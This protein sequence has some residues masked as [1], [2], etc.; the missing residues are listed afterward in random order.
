MT[1]SSMAGRRALVTGAAS[2]IGEAI[3]EALAGAGAKVHLVGSPRRPDRVA[4]VAERITERT[5]ASITWSSV[6]VVDDASVA[7]AVEIAAGAMGGVDCVVTSAGVSAPSD[8]ADTTPLHRLTAGQLRDVLDVNLRGTWSTLH[9]A[10]RHLEQARPGPATV[11]TLGSVAGKR[12]THGAYSVS[13]CAVWMLTRVLADQWAPLGI[14]ANCLAPGSIDTPMLR[15]VA[16]DSGADD[17]DAWLEARAAR[18]PLRRVGTVEEVAAAALFLSG[19]ES[20]YVTGALLH[21]DG[22]LVNANAGG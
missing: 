1:S 21:P 8:T 20:S 6:D 10:A 12:P 4:A 14:R 7:G 22:G 2:G 5:G 16:E 19:P 9:H 3:A 13:K 17:V 11:V 15:R 18:I